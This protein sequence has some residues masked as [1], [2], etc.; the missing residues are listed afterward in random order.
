MRRRVS[1]ILLTGLLAGAVGTACGGGE[2]NRMAMPPPPPAPA[3]PAP[4]PEQTEETVETRVAAMMATNERATFAV[5]TRDPFTQPRPERGPDG[6]LEGPD[7][8]RDCEILE[9]PLGQTEVDELELIGLIT[10]TAVPRAMFLARGDRQAVMVTEGDSVGP[11]CSNRITSIRDNEVVI[12]PYTVGETASS[13]I[14]LQLNDDRL[15]QRFIQ[16][17]D[18]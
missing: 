9:Q 10:G 14:Y 4:E 6:G 18:S 8:A 5:D 2:D 11:N 17:E 7:V 16:I 15:N 13:P 3:E 1:T 12:E